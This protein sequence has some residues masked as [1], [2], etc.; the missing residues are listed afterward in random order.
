MAIKAQALV[1]F[2][3]EFTHV[4]TSDPAVEA[5]E[6]QDQGDDQGKVLI[7]QTPSNE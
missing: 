5:H 2:I 4:V 3:P 7:L 6:K 1:D